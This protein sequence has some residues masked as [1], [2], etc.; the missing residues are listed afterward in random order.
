MDRATWQATVYE[1][2]KVRHDLATEC[3]LVQE[4]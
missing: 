3:A 4:K 2:E 1:V